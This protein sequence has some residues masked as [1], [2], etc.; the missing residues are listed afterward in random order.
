MRA[1]LV[2]AVAIC[3]GSLTAPSGALAPA[4]TTGAGMPALILWAW[5]RP[6]DLRFID[7]S[8]IGV[9]FLARTLRL[10][11]DRVAQRPRLQ[12]IAVPDDTHLTAVVRVEIGETRPAL[13]EQQ[14]S[15]TADQ[16]VAA[17]RPGVSAV[18]I[19][20]DA[21]VT[22]RPF[23][24]ALIH[25]VRARM[26]AG[27]A[28]S[29]TA[30]ASWCAGDRWMGDL[31]IDEAVPMMFRMGTDRLVIERHLRHAGGFDAAPCDTSI[32]LSTDEPMAV[33][34]ARRTYVFS[35]TPWTAASVRQ[36]EARVMR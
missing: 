8:R 29:I 11:G 4:S 20:F 30:L 3:L 17:I 15:R 1:R 36:V 13:S 35:P 33:R 19:D 9:A 16:I 14:R 10:D 25:D 5:E 32:G 6:E 27:L 34:R 23:Y 18:Q 24:R 28:L 12:P 22:Q 7:A 21:T 2:L 26:P 31:P